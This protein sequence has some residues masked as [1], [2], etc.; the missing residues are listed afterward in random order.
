MSYEKPQEPP[1]LQTT[2]GPG[3]TL[4]PLDGTW[5]VGTWEVGLL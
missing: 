2:K 4:S 1:G 3:S 5:E